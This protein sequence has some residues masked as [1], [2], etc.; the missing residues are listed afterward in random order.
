MT[1]FDDVGEF[2]AKF[3]LPRQGMTPVRFMPSDEFLY[4][5]AF[6]Q[7]E[8]TEFVRAFGRRD[9]AE[10]LDALVDKVYVALGTAHFMGLPFNEAWREVH[11]CNLQK[12]A[13]P[14]KK[15]GHRL[16]VRKPEG[17]VG[18]DHKL[19]LERAGWTE[20]GEG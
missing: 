9:M 18:P 1:F 4:R 12:E 16:D 17:W 8:E 3:C 20:A 19:I 2:H 10:C 15:R 13:G 5:I 11:G 7:E 6:H 14:T